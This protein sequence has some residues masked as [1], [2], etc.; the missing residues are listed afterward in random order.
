MTYPPQICDYFDEATSTVTYLVS[1]P[2][3]GEAAIIDPVL[4]YDHRSGKLGTRAAEAVIAE[5]RSLG[6]KVVWVLETHAH[7]DHLTAASFIKSQTGAQ[8]AIG[9]HIGKVQATFRSI[10]NL[11]DVSTTGAE[12]DRL[13]KD[14]E[15]FM[16]GALEVSVL[17]TPGHT[18]AC[19]SYKIGD[20]VF[21]GDTVF[22]P[23]YGTARA[24]FPGGDAATLYRSIQRILSLPPETRLF[25]CHDYKA[26]G[27]DQY[28]WQSSVAEER[29]H[30]IHIHDGISEAEFVSSR[31]MRDA[32]LA[33]PVLLLPSIQVNIRAGRL[34]KPEGNGSRYLKIPMRLD[35]ALTKSAI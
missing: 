19:V 8:I 23:D 30:N 29:A 22:M 4:N 33:A 6:L 5:A 27:R 20:A 14:G 32:T 17:H 21:V 7:A 12:F 25:M 13:L 34:P 15:T 24:D 11:D 28:R 2:D 10:F 18:P 9:E 3:T 1:D 35:P 31:E 16:L 26:P